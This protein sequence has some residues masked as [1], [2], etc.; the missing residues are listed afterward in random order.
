L[1]A[2]SA[3]TAHTSCWCCSTINEE[4]VGEAL[5]PFKGQV[6]V[7]TKF[8]FHF[9]RDGKKMWLNSIGLNETGENVA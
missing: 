7:A 5:A 9:D 1:L 3:C 4:L 2:A 8:G 6:V